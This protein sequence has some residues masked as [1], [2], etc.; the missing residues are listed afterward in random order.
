VL[1]LRAPRARA[2]D[3]R[4]LR[5]RGGPSAALGSSAERG[6]RR[7]PR[8]DRAK[9]W[10]HRPPAPLRRLTQRSVPALPPFR[11]RSFSEFSGDQFWEIIACGGSLS[12][13]TLNLCENGASS[14]VKA[15]G[16]CR[17]PKARPTLQPALIRP[18]FWQCV[19]RRGSGST[20]TKCGE[21]A[22]H[23]ACRGSMTRLTIAS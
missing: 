17:H 20:R 8:S 12:F 4:G 16:G 1:A 7:S 18:N 23:W 2:P 5:P 19:P 21:R 22:V 13:H 14:A 10:T 11:G 3:K 9:R 6:R 15:G